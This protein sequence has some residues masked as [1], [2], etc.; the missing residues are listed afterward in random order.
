GGE[1]FIR[2]DFLDIYI[3]AKKKGFIITIFTNATLINHRIAS[4]MADWPPYRIEVTL[5]GASKKVYEKITSVFGSYDKCRKGINMLLDKNI[6]LDLKT[7]VS[8]LNIHELKEIKDF[9]RKFG[10]NF[11]FD[12]LLHSRIDGSHHP[13]QYRISPEEVVRLDFEDVERKKSW[14]NIVEK[15]GIIEGKGIDFLYQCGAGRSS[16]FLDPF[17]NIS[18]CSMVLNPAYNIR[19]HSF[20]EIW[21]FFSEILSS[22]R[23]KEFECKD[24]DIELF[25]QMCPA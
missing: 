22:K 13:C 15:F 19:E 7:M 6:P 23:E 18:I 12:P 14:R 3:Y 16:F 4:L 11:R 10:L 20:R 2:E 17:G 5:Y 24:C 21:S 25:C 9:A 8:S 1:P